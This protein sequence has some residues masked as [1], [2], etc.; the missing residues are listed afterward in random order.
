MGVFYVCAAVAVGFNILP[1]S[2]PC[3][4]VSCFFIRNDTSLL[5][6]PLIPVTVLLITHSTQKYKYFLFS[7]S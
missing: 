5:D 4:F 2:H 6:I 1:D 3:F 7:L